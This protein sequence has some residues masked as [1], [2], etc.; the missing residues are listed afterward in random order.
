MR[1]FDL[2]GAFLNQDGRTWVVPNQK[3]PKI[4]QGNR[5]SWECSLRFIGLGIGLELMGMQS[6]IHWQ[7][8]RN[9]NS[10]IQRFIGREIGTHGNAVLRFIG[11]E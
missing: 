5:D 7:G 8:N 3:T 1:F 6:E 11:R 10:S 9:L 2:L 4:L